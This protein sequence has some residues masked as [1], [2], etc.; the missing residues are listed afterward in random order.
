[1]S[2]SG[3]KQMI[4]EWMA[5]D[6]ESAELKKRLRQ[7]TA[8]KK[9]IS[10]K[11]L[12]IMKD[13]KIDEFDLNTDGKLVRQTKLSKQSINKKNLPMILTSYYENEEEAVKVAEFILNSRPEKVVES[14]RKK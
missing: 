8:K 13:Q 11:L 7:F 1:M 4:K 10:E 12:V 2:M 14:I 6:A 5:I 9:E 3:I